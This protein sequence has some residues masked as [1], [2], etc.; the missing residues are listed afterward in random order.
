MYFKACLHS[1]GEPSET[2]K[3]LN[4]SIM[5]IILCTL[6]LAFIRQASRLKPLAR[7]L[8][9]GLTKDDHSYTHYIGPYRDL[10]TQDLGEQQ[11]RRRHVCAS[12][13]RRYCYC[14]CYLVE[15]FHPIQELR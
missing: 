15:S 9:V 2:F 11:V 5:I 6:K 12:P 1:T 7:R 10:V 13:N 8:R 3:P 14:Y 4:L